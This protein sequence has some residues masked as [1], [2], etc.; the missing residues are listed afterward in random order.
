[1]K[2]TL[3][4]IIVA[5]V[6]VLIVASLFALGFLTGPSNNPC[7][8]TESCSASQPFTVQVGGR[9]LNPAWSP[10]YVVVDLISETPG[11]PPAMTLQTPK[12]DFWNNNY[13]LTLNYCISYPSGTTYCTG[14]AFATLPVQTGTVPG[15]GCCSTGVTGY[16]FYAYHNGPKGLYSIQVTLTWTMT[17]CNLGATCASGTVTKASSFSV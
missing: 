2:R 17:G 15:G 1:M 9:V 8:A 6:A 7:P 16:T 3:F 10:P 12:L 11:G 4:L 13:A 14:K 5:V